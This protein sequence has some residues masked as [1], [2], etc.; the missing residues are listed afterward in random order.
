MQLCLQIDYDWNGD[1]KMNGKVIYHECG[2]DPMYKTWHADENV[3]IIYMHS[4]G[5]SIVCSEKAYPIEEGVLCFV[6]A[7]KHH[8]TMPDEPDK[9]LRS[10]VFI[11]A[12]QLDRILDVVSQDRF[13]G[14]FTNHTVVYARVKKEEQAEVD[15]IYRE[16]STYANH[17]V[18]GELVTASGF[19]KLLVCLDKYSLEST[20]GVSGF[21]SKAVEYINNN[22]FTDID[23]DKICS[24]INVSKYYFCR[25]F[26]QHTGMTVMEYILKTRII[27]AKNMLS[28]VNISIT[29]VSERCGFSSI[30]YFCR[31]FKEDTGMTPLKY[32][33]SLIKCVELIKKV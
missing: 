17:P 16:M 7:G 5:G 15:A 24:Y 2:K 27:L 29:Q 10:K 12:K 28:D 21:M 9:Y 30:S 3:M 1:D 22:I 33:K 18:Y 26:K 25:Q 19:M 23:I 11:S 32:R 4:R 14:K 13:W 8:Y 20:P 31:V 6:G